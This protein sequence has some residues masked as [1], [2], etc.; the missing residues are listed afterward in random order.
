LVKG[1]YH[2]SYPRVEGASKWLVLFPTPIWHPTLLLSEIDRKIGSVTWFP[3]YR[4]LIRLQTHA[5]VSIF[6]V[7]Y[8][9]N[10]NLDNHVET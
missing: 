2:R 6:A 10:K 1:V 7:L 3:V 8:V 4:S 5:Y 9:I